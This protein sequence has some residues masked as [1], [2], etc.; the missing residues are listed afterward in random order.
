MAKKRK[1]KDNGH[2]AAWESPRESGGGRA[3]SQGVKYWGSTGG[4]EGHTGFQSRL[5]GVDPV[6]KTVGTMG[7]IKQAKLWSELHL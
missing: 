5:R 7:K 4:A 3:A 1:F 2:T 6:W